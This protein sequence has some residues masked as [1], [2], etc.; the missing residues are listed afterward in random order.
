MTSVWTLKSDF[1]W[2]FLCPEF[3]NEICSNFTSTCSTPPH[4][5]AETAH[6][7][8]M[9]KKFS[10]FNLIL[11]VIC[12]QICSLSVQYTATSPWQHGARAIFVT[13]VLLTM[14]S[15]HQRS[16]HATMF[17]DVTQPCMM[18]NQQV[19]ITWPQEPAVEVNWCML[20]LVHSELKAKT[21]ILK[22]T[23]WESMQLN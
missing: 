13:A 9:I 10:L 3:L 18:H 21:R 14:F 15:R 4:Q 1:T 8:K 11:F 23:Q 7:K 5:V 20:V 16:R 6:K 19:L 2:L 22:W 17:N 12:S